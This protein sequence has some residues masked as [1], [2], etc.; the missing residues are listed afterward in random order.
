MCRVCQ[1]MGFLLRATGSGH[2][3][4]NEVHAFQDGTRALGE[5]SLT[6]SGT[7]LTDV[8]LMP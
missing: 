5:L 4:L 3:P 1:T 2:P 6:L 7:F 8:N